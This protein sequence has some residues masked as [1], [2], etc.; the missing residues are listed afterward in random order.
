MLFLLNRVRINFTCL[1][2]VAFYY[3]ESYTVNRSR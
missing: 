2:Y 1:C 3:T